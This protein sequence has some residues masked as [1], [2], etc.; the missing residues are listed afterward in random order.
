MRIRAKANPSHIHPFLPSPW[1]EYLLY[2]YLNTRH[3]KMRA[4]HISLHTWISSALQTIFL[5][6]TFRFL[7][8][9]L[10][11]FLCLLWISCQSASNILP[12]VLCFL[13]S[14]LADDQRQTKTKEYDTPIHISIL[15]ILTLKSNSR[16]LWI[17]ALFYFNFNVS[18]SVVPTY[19][20]MQISFLN[21]LKRD[22]SH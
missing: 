1:S 13:L 16:Y 4:N 9:P 8:G 20:V 22:T 3:T 12:S 11:D 6:A 5:G 19:I 17:L 2:L 21:H 10:S 7:P 15:Q 14:S 18:R